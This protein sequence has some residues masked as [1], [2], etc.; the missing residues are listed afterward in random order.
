MATGMRM[1]ECTMK[2]TCP[3]RS[4]DEFV[5]EC[6]MIISA[7]ARW[8]SLEGLEKLD[9][10]A[11]T[12]AVERR[13]QVR[14]QVSISPRRRDPSASPDNRHR[15]W[16]HCFGDHRPFPAWRMEDKRPK[17]DVHQ[18]NCSRLHTRHLDHRPNSFASSKRCWPARHRRSGCGRSFGA[19][20]LASCGSIPR[21]LVIP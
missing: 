21:E 5:L 4:K 7:I 17:V 19:V 18:F 8:R 10:D 3:S 20:F 6:D 11:E 2:A 14:G 16:P 12:I 9:A 13:L 15:P 1:C